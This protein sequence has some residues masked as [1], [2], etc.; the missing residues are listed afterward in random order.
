MGSVLFLS[1]LL[2]KHASLWTLKSTINSIKITSTI[3]QRIRGLENCVL[4]KIFPNEDEETKCS[5]FSKKCND[6][7]AC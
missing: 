1:V 7:K 5:M 4:R 6:T 2:L 3:S